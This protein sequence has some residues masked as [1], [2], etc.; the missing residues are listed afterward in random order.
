MWPCR[1]GWFGDHRFIAQLL[2]RP[3]WFPSAADAAHRAG[4]LHKLRL[5]DV[6]AVFLLQGH[7]AEVI[8]QFFVAQRQNAFGRNDCAELFFEFVKSRKRDKATLKS[9]TRKS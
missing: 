6:M 7:G 9:S 8:F 2:S 1:S 3:H 4:G 5:A